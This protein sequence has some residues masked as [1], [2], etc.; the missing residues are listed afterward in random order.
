[1]EAGLVYNCSVFEVILKYF[2]VLK[3]IKKKV[4]KHSEHESKRNQKR[5]YNCR[6][7]VSQS[8]IPLCVNA[9]RRKERIVHLSNWCDPIRPVNLGQCHELKHV[10]SRIA[11]SEPNRAIWA[12]QYSR[13]W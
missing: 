2:S 9:Q 11:S 7:R 13:G 5:V 1:M 3:A 6:L 4:E 8:S 12:R 10:G